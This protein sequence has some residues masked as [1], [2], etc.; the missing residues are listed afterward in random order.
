MRDVQSDR[1]HELPLN[2]GFSGEPFQSIGDLT[3]ASPL[4]RVKLTVLD[5][6]LPCFC[7]HPIVFTWLH[8]LLDLLCP[9]TL[10]PYRP[11]VLIHDLTSTFHRFGLPLDLFSLFV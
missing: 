1:G 10:A 5:R 6:K 8:L 3:V 4:A 11:L 7:C 9:I 2:G